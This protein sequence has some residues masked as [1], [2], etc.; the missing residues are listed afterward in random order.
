MSRSL[1][2]GPERGCCFVVLALLSACAEPISQPGV[3]PDRKHSWEV[4]F[5]HGDSAAVAALYAQDAQLVMSGSPPISGKAGIED[6][7]RKMIQSGVKVRIGAQR[8]RGSGSI[9]YVYGSYSVLD[10]EGGREI[11]N[12]AYLEIWSNHQGTWL[13]DLDVNAA[14]AAT[15]KP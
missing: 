10:R 6:A 5:N 4:A 15:L 1:T 3:S 8:N 9:A 12:G 11:E 13:I 14:G 2:L 7:V